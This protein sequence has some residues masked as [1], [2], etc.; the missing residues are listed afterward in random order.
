MILLRMIS[1]SA[2]W[3]DTASIYDA[4]GALSQQVRDRLRLDNNKLSVWLGDKEEDKLD[5]IVALSLNR[6]NLQRI[7]L[8]ELEENDLVQMGIA[9]DDSQLGDC[10][11]L[12]DNSILAKHRDL[13][14]QDDSAL[15]LLASYI[16][17]RVEGQKVHT[18]SKGQVK[19]LL[20]SYEGRIDVT[21]VSPNM[22]N[23]FVTDL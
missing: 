15:A 12:T 3:S 23:I 11:A 6:Q 18:T 9:I 14:I 13:I 1:S 2:W 5:A 22:R 16:V 20:K 8:V 7:T 17:K 21:K 19:T 4:N 10:P